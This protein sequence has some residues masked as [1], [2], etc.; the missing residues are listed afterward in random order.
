MH[1]V[2]FWT[3]KMCMYSYA[4]PARDFTCLREHWE[5]I[6]LSGKARGRADI[7]SRYRLACLCV[8]KEKR[9][10]R[11]SCVDRIALTLAIDVH[12]V[13]S[14]ANMCL[15]AFVCVCVCVY[16]VTHLQRLWDKNIQTRTRVQLTPGGRGYTIG[17]VHPNSC[18]WR[19][20]C[21]MFG[22]RNR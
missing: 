5:Y 20:C 7:A 10:R 21:D 11:L 1:I 9:T 8:R 4:P 3:H 12:T 18:S 14:F 22:T 17:A 2:Y 6:I 16:T 19:G 15:S 13:A